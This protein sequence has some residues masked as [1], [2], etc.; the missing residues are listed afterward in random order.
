[1]YSIYIKEKNIKQNWSQKMKKAL[2]L[3]NVY[4]LNTKNLIS[5]NKDVLKKLVIDVNLNINIFL[6]SQK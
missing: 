5:K 1:M 4:K 2:K 6:D 3:Q